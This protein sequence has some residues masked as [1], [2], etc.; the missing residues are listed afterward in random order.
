MAILTGPQI[1]VFQDDLDNSEIGNPG[2]LW[3]KLAYQ[4][5]MPQKKVNTLR[6]GE[7]AAQ[8]VHWLEMKEGNLEQLNRAIVDIGVSRIQF[9][10]PEPEIVGLTIN[11]PPPKLPVPK[12]KRKWL[13]ITFTVSISLSVL[14]CVFS[15]YQLPTRRYPE[16]TIA[17]GGTKMVFVQIPAGEFIMVHH[18]VNL[19]MRKTIPLI[20]PPHNIV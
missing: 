11:P 19:R 4:L 18:Q 16:K 20:S 8:I 15:F 14:I 10:S 7:Q 12:S 9:P 1:N 5:D 6:V 13:N 17:I 2:S 3:V